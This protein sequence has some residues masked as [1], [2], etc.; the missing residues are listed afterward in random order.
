MNWDRR[1]LLRLESERGKQAQDSD[2]E[3]EKIMG[4]VAAA[5][6]AVL[7]PM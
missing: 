1:T 2:S 7:S 6:R 4:A 3:R 5:R